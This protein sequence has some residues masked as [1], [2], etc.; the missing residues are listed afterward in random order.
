[1]A[2]CDAAALTF[3]G[4]DNSGAG[5][6]IPPR[7]GAVAGTRTIQLPDAMSMALDADGACQ[8]ARISVHLV[9]GA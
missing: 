4:Q 6:Y 9:V 1:A 7:A 8:S 2:G 3:V 5:W